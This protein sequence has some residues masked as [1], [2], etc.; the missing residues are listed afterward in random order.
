MQKKKVSDNG[1]LKS[2]PPERHLMLMEGSILFGNLALIVRFIWGPRT[3]GLSLTV[4][5][6][7]S[8]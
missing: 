1:T 6:T 3:V 5:V 4:S 2:V 7:I 8:A